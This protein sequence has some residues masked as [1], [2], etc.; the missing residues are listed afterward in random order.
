MISFSI[1]TE[2]SRENII[3]K[4]SE[5]LSADAAD[6]FAELVYGLDLSLDDVE[7]AVTV[8]CGCAL[9]RVFDM[10]RYFFL[11]PCRWV[12]PPRDCNRIHDRRT[13]FGPDP[14]RSACRCVTGS[15][16]KRRCPHR[17][18]TISTRPSRV[19]HIWSLPRLRRSACSS[20]NPRPFRRGL[21][22]RSRPSYG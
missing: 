6:C 4:F 9:I 19:Q 14:L 12:S 1:I 18:R 10:G 7:L 13:G 22:T 17:L 5:E 21:S 11:F 8:S 2:D 20:G 3:R 16:D 15:P